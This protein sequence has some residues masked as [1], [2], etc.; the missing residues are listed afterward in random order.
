MI[1]ILEH[2]A[3]Y[4]VKISA[5]SL[6]TLFKEGARSIFIMAGAKK[7]NKA[8]FK[9]RKI[10]VKAENLDSLFYNFVEK[11]LFYFNIYKEIYYK[12]EFK[13]FNLKNFKIKALLFSKPIKFQAKDIK[14]IS[15]HNLHIARKNGYYYTFVVFDV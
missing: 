6:K 5:K 15:Y 8:S 4:K 3:D 10:S 2:T 13:E 1:E 11:V 7:N 14:A 9:K 12:I